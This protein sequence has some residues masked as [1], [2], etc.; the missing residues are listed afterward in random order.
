PT[1]RALLAGAAAL[2]VAGAGGAA[3]WLAKD[4]SGPV[5]GPTRRP[6]KSPTRDPGG[7]PR[8]LWTY[9]GDIS[10]KGAVT[11]MPI[12]DIVVLPG[13]AEG[14]LIGLDIRRG[15]VRWTAGAG[16]GI[17]PV[18]CAG[19]I[20]QPTADPDGRLAVV[21]AADGRT[22]TTGPLGLDFSRLLY[23]F[24]GFGE[25]MVI[26]MGHATGADP[27][28][29]PQDVDRFLVAYDVVDRKV[30]WRRK[31]GRSTARI[32]Q[33]AGSDRL[34]VLLET[35]SVTAYRLDD[36]RPVWRRALATE[37]T[38]ISTETGAARRA[39]ATDDRTVVVSGR[40][41]LVLELA[42]G[43]T[44]WS[45]DPEEAEEGM[46]E[47]QKGRTLYGAA[48]IDGNEVYLSFL[49]RELWVIRRDKRKRA[50]KGNDWRWQSTVRLA[51]APAAPPEPAGPYLFPPLIDTADV[52]A[53][54]VDR[55][56]MKTAWTYTMPGEP[57]GVI[58]YLGAKDRLYVTRGHTLTVLPVEGG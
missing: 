9:R 6:P 55:K 37:R 24:A 25:R 3:W 4:D 21:E 22:W 50:R 10:D 33:M 15:T 53:I 34:G 14:S 43:R 23:P 36:G 11:A 8:P 19:A 5:G 57:T 58:R 48:I 28:A 52:T 12:G 17:A 1:R 39:L 27:E 30:V 13:S 35:D 41:L 47:R 54:A 45:L 49:G 44:V 38:V 20:L 31:L 2:V 16:I 51:A 29:P 26:L 56:T 42:T 18:P 7:A 46:T 40:G 32:G